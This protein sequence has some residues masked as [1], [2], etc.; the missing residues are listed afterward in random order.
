M[1][2]YMMSNR[3]TML[4]L[5]YNRKLTTYRPT[6]EKKHDVKYALQ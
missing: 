6:V 3:T 1:Y 2:I 4:T 5:L